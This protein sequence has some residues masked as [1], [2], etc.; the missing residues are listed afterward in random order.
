LIAANILKTMSQ[1]H[2]VGAALNN[3]CVAIPQV[4]FTP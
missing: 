2:F 4:R 3:F 1:M